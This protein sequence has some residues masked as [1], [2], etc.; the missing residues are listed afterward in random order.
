MEKRSLTGLVV[1][2]LGIFVSA[3][4]FLSFKGDDSLASIIIGFLI[5]IVGLIIIFNKNED[6]IEQINYKGG[7]SK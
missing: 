3:M 5:S 2:V 6:L 7:K 4:G 1:L